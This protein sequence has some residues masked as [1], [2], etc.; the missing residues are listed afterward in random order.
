M[1]KIAAVAVLSL[2]FVMTNAYASYD[3]FIKID[4]IEGESTQNHPGE[5]EISSFSWGMT[6]YGDPTGSGVS[7]GKASFSDLTVTKQV[8]KTSPKLVDKAALGELIKEV[9][10]TAKESGTV[11]TH[12][13]VIT[14]EDAMIS[15]ISVSGDSSGELM[16]NVSF[17]YGKISIEYITQTPDGD[18]S[19]QSKQHEL[20][21]HVTLIK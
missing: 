21:G 2:M 5:I 1:I 9:K 19:A 14:L 13:Y 11:W 15:S 8:D 7:S 16:E 10:F 18:Q 20:R 3:Y 12:S 4:S 6:Q 17:N